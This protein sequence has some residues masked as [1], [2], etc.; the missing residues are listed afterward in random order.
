MDLSTIISDSSRISKIPT[1]I[2]DEEFTV[3]FYNAA[4]KE[5]FPGIEGGRPF[6]DYAVIYDKADLMRTRYPSSALIGCGEKRY[7][8][9]F[10]PVFSGYSKECVFSVAVISDDCRDCE[11]Y[12]SMKLAVLSKCFSSSDA[13][14]ACAGKAKA[15][16]RLYS[17]YEAYLRMLT[18]VSG[19]DAVVTADIG[20][21]LEDALSYYCTL[22]YGKSAALRYFVE[23]DLEYIR[24][25]R[26][27]CVLLI[28]IYNICSRLSSNGCCA[29]SVK[30]NDGGDI[31]FSMTFRPGGRLVSELS[32][33]TNKENA[34]YSALGREA[35]DVLLIKILARMVSGQMDM[36]YEPKAKTAKV[37]LTVAESRGSLLHSSGEELLLA[38]RISAETVV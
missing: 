16:S 37:S 6:D 23:T 26:L 10:C 33:D 31:V 4:A 38:A 36:L 34:V 22:R 28:E 25:S 35:A 8:C 15:F 27:T 3:S 24:M 30:K 20:R 7:F 9:A 2:T 5:L 32:R 18:V 17:K 13:D 21:L 1:V 29:V 12:L 14:T 11:Q 19:D